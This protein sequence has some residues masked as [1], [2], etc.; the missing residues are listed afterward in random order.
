MLL[1]ENIGQGTI[2]DS[3]GKKILNLLCRERQLTKQE[4]AQRLGLSIPTVISNVSDLIAEGLL[5]EAGVGDSTGGRKPVIIGFKPEARYSF[6][7]DI[8]PSE[9]R[10][11]L[12]DLD[13]RILEDVRFPIRELRKF[14]NIAGEVVRI[15]Q[16]IIGQRRIFKDNILGVGFSLPGTVN[17]EALILENAPNLGVANVSFQQFADDL[18][19][20]VYTENEANAAAY[21]ESTLGVFAEMNNLVYVSITKGI[22]T[23]IVIKGH[24]YKGKNKRAGEFGHMTVDAHGK[25]C[26]CGRKG[27][28]E[29]Y[30]SERGLLD[31]YKE[32]TGTALSS[33]EE[34]FRRVQSNETT[35]EEALEKYL[36]YLAIGIQNIILLLDPDYVV[37]G[38][39]IAKYK[40]VFFE[41]LTQK[42]FVNNSFFKRNDT[43]ILFSKLQD[44]ASII[45]ASL[46]PMRTIFFL[47]EKVI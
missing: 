37:V 17:E 1:P 19:L 4:I 29:V 14:E 26:N 2:K 5:E 20:P 16:G 47:D 22:G 33:I 40:D 42:V 28:W 44:D 46:L 7:V 32:L 15:I 9:G 35:A 10:I 27:C 43:I 39:I 18:N 11:I 21:A 34:V 30:A 3:N 12:T 31:S 36:D 38:G 8:A 41:K 23:G 45:G 13:S 25:A 24:L 6:G